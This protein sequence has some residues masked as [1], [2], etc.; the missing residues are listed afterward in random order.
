MNTD[1]LIELLAR[2]AG[3]APRRLTRRRLAP[4]LAAGALASLGLALTLFRPLPA[5]FWATPAPWFKLVYAGALAVSAGLLAARL[6]RP[7]TSA[8]PAWF[9]LAGVALSAALVGLLTLAYEPAGARLTALFGA[10]WTSCPWRVLGLSLPALAATLWALHG[11]A[12]TSPPRA[13]LAAGLLSGSLGAL[14]YS[15]VCPEPSPAF[16]ASWYSLGIGLSGALGAG[17]GARMLRW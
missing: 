2:H 16:V 15:L 4:A 17:L 6:G 10:S 9:A 5:D 12:P 1:T 7:G 14:G 3:Q 13:G 11:L 8:R